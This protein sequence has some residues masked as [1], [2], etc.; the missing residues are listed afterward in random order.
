MTTTQ[1]HGKLTWTS[2][3]SQTDEIKKSRGGKLKYLQTSRQMD[4]QRTQR[5]E[6]RRIFQSEGRTSMPFQR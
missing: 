1:R 2:V 4:T 6:L 5:R 3:L